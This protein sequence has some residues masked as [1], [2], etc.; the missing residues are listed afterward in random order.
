MVTRMPPALPSTVSKARM[1][2][3][4]PLMTLPSA[5]TVPSTPEEQ[6]ARPVTVQMTRVSK[7]VPVLWM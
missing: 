7:K 2:S 6:M 4:A 5:P 3:A 1:V